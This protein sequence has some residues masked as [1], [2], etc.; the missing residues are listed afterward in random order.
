MG[1]RSNALV[2]AVGAH[3][4][5][6]T[7][8]EGKGMC[9]ESRSP[10]WF[11]FL[12]LGS[13]A[14]FVAWISRG[15]PSTRNPHCT[16]HMLELLRTTL[17]S[18]FCLLYSDPNPHFARGPKPDGGCFWAHEARKQ[19]RDHQTLGQTLEIIWQLDQVSV[20][21]LLYVF[22]NIL[23]KPITKKTQYSKSFPFHWQTCKKQLELSLKYPHVSLGWLLTVTF[24]S[25]AG[26]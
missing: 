26:W 6:S 25:Y 23:N 3:E 7:R 18:S 4:K 14:P 8:E 24:Y 12:N 19:Q 15:L 11:I 9:H 22:I 17:G 13:S 20:V 16:K 2:E 10:I 21:L 1:S 5:R